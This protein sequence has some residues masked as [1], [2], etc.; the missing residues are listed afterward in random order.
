MTPHPLRSPP[1][2][3]PPRAAP[4]RPAQAS[5]PPPQ[6]HPAAATWSRC[7]SAGQMWRDSQRTAAWWSGPG[8]G[9]PQGRGPSG[10]GQLSSLPGS[11][12]KWRPA[13]RGLQ[14]GPTPDS[15][16]SSRKAH[17]RR[18]WG[19]SSSTSLCSAMPESEWGR[20]DGDPTPDWASSDGSSWACTFVRFCVPMPL[21][22]AFSP[23]PAPGALWQPPPASGPVPSLVEDATAL[24]S[25]VPA[26]RVTL[27]SNEA[28]SGLLWVLFARTKHTVLG[29]S[30]FYC[31]NHQMHNVE[32]TVDTFT[33]TTSR[34]LTGRMK[35]NTLTTIHFLVA[36][37]SAL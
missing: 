30:L 14:S 19:S 13:S 12:P 32:K 9:D 36:G 25:W 34:K 22:A 35:L 11:T 21:I 16:G 1:S 2:G 23:P 3:D 10:Q 20:K 5:A 27:G 7:P 24:S 6:T 8:N 31:P 37:S 4:A 15:K 33:S 29:L 26:R 17:S 18:P 28:F